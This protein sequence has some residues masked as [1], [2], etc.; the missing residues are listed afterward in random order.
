MLAEEVW[1]FACC[2]ANLFQKEAREKLQQ[3]VLDL[4]EKFG[5]LEKKMKD[6]ESKNETA[7]MNDVKKML[8]F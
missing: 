6:L 3:Q 1:I 2:W 5:A 8:N 7:A 4:T